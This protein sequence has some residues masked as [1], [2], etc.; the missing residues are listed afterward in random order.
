MKKTA[1]SST[2]STKGDSNSNTGEIENPPVTETPS[3]GTEFFTDTT[4]LKYNNIYWNKL[5]DWH[6]YAISSF[7][8]WQYLFYFNPDWNIHRMD[9]DGNNDISIGWS[10]RNIKASERYVYSLTI[11]WGPVYEVFRRSLDGSNAITFVNMQYV[12]DY[13]QSY[14]S[15]IDYM[16]KNQNFY[17]ITPDWNI[18]SKNED[19]LVDLD[20]WLKTTGPYFVTN[21]EILYSNKN[22][23]WKGYKAWLDWS[24][25]T[26]IIEASNISNIQTDGIYYYYKDTNWFHKQKI[27]T[28]I[29]TDLNL[30]N[31]S[32]RLI[33]IDGEYLIF[34]DASSKAIRTDK[35]WWNVKNIFDAAMKS[36]DIK[37]WNLYT[38]TTAW[39]VYKVNIASPVGYGK[40]DDI[41]ISEKII[42]SS[43]GI[44]INVNST[45][46]LNTNYE[47]YIANK[48]SSQ[49]LVL[50]GILDVYWNYI[51]NMMCSWFW[52]LKAGDEAILFKG[53]STKTVTI[54]SVDSCS[55]NLVSDSGINDWGYGLKQW[56]QNFKLINNSILDW[57]HLIDLT[58]NDLFWTEQ[59]TDLWYKV[60]LKG[61]SWDNSKTPVINSIKISK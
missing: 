25:P 31:S 21:T 54:S 9:G 5:A 34:K 2:G 48:N 45:L 56:V 18:H 52:T 53:A 38:A 3:L 35:N 60:I 10:Q 14:G 46:S 40:D 8:N 42:N 44:Y 29:V 47:F 39:K 19:T 36:W 57:Q 15:D 11:H 22:D 43:T 26:K 55:I 13:S 4:P 17:Y 49:T 27:D 24:N 6:S 1:N 58:T 37:N 16:V 7:Y 12:T 33:G 32:S 28:G 41:K 51:E 50:E 20:T 30:I 23:S 61:D 59:T